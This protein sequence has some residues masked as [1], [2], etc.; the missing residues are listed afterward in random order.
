MGKQ[1]TKGSGGHG[2]Y[3]C[4]NT[5][6][7]R[8]VLGGKSAEQNEELM[9]DF[10]GK[11]NIIMHTEKPGSPFCIILG[12]NKPAKSDIREA[13][14]FCARHSREWKKDNSDVLVHAFSGKDAYKDKGMKK[15]TFGVGKIRR[16]I[17]VKKKEINKLNN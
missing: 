6:S 7:G 11:G 4:F 1:K 15:G 9:N 2:K 5:S 13:A 17:R 12:E 3:R 16:K 8:L 14:V 10:I